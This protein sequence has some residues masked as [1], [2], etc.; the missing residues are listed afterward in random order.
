MDLTEFYEVYFII[1]RNPFTVLLDNFHSPN[2]RLQL[3]KGHIY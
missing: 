1:N 3:E 2:K